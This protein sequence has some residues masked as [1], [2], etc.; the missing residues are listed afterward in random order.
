MS[1]WLLFSMCLFYL[2][3][4]F[5]IA[6]YAERKSK[7]G[8]SLI[9]NPFV[10]AL[11]L[12]TYC[13][14]WTFYGSVGK[15]ATS[16]IGFL[17]T[18]LGPIILAGFWYI[19]FKWVIRICKIQ[20]IT[21]IA[22][23]IASRYGSSSTIGV[24]VTLVSILSIVP[25][26][27]L[28]LKAISQS[29][30]ILYN[31]IN[32]NDVIIS[33]NTGMITAILMSVFIMIFGT[34]KIDASERQEGMVFAIAF[35]ALFK[36]FAFLAIGIYV[37]FFVFDGF[38]D[39]FQKASDALILDRLTSIGDTSIGG[40]WDWFM[41]INLSFFAFMLLPRQFYLI[42]VQ[43]TDEK[44]SSSAAWMFLLYLLAI[45]I[46]IIPIALGG[47]IAFQ[48]SNVNADTF[49]LMFPIS[50]GHYFLSLIVFFG[51][52]A[53]ATGMII[54]SAYA[55]SMMLTN[56]ILL[57]STLRFFDGRK[58]LNYPK[59]ILLLRRVSIV[60]I[61][62]LSY[63]FL[64]SV[65]KEYPLVEI[66]LIS[67]VGIIQLAPSFF[68]AILW[69][70]GNKK[71]V[72]TGMVAGTLVW[73][74]TLVL[75]TVI[76][77][78]LMLNSE[79]LT[80]GIFGL[81][82]FR[83][84]ALFGFMGMGNIVHGMFW[85]IL[86]NSIGYFLVSSFTQPTAEELKKASEFSAIGNN[87][88]SD[89]VLMNQN[90]NAVCFMKIQELLDKFFGPEEAGKLVQQYYNDYG[91]EFAAYDK[92]TASFIDY[93]ENLL[94]G[95]VG[96]ATSRI[97]ISKIV[98]RINLEEGDLIKAGSETR[99]III[100]S[101]ELE[102]KSKELE[103]KTVQLQHANERLKELD[104]MKDN[105]V[106]SVSHELRTPLTSIRAFAEMLTN[107]NYDLSSKQDEFLNIIAKE[108]TRLSNLIDDILYF[109]KLELKRDDF[110]F[111]EMELNSLLLE[112]VTTLSPIASK[113]SVEIKLQAK[114]KELNI[115]ADYNKLKQVIINIVNNSLKFYN[116]EK[117]KRLIIIRADKEADNVKI[118]IYDNGIGIA[119][120]EINKV[121]KE[122]YQIGAGEEIKPVGSGLG[123]AISKKIIDLHN[124]SIH[125]E[126]IEGEQTEFII[127][128]PQKI[129]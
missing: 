95:V 22:D 42:G 17:P 74:F 2:V 41:L 12:T 67:F 62:L 28:Q 47:L 61:M 94:T 37:T 128:L 122:F 76:H 23:F 20:R 69:K 32:D 5:G 48:G 83:P 26:I 31:N 35:E 50:N 108:S 56:N 53:A 75:P 63:M 45:N 6:Y 89:R 110:S 19:L 119:K 15:A 66:G 124:G 24:L 71:G 115:Y 113:V 13:T 7:P 88:V 96:S 79:I 81:G 117:E 14:A 64:V 16:G 72:I 102:A 78:G 101:K 58:D 80:Q 111:K 97:L 82:I 126:S 38:G 120:S 52:F 27:S 99:D 85:S 121:F 129:N 109:E 18:Y 36:L 105:F 92:V 39:I 1:L 21:S 98:K 77:T 125:I 84:Y 87:L 8:K 10:Y 49:V 33:T 86:A 127:S 100:H 73:V 91:I 116:Q 114:E 93:T 34:R 104:E 59:V 70:G 11:S 57:P 43:S 60:I 103:I 107:K 30:D 55:V 40:Y 118:N 90:I 4:L 51:G 68:G 44:H 29:F 65:G 3:F 54:A 106:A 9:N 112:V 25:Y 46:F 123:L